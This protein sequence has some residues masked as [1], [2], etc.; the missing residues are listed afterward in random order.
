MPVLIRAECT[1]DLVIFQL[2]RHMVKAQVLCIFEVAMHIQHGG[3]DRPR[4]A[5]A[6][7]DQYH[8]GI[9]RKP[10]RPAGCLPLGFHNVGTDR[11]S[12]IDAFLRMRETGSGCFVAQRDLIDHAG[13]DLIRDPGDHILLLDQRRDMRQ[14]RRH[15]DRPAY[16]AAR[17]DDYIRCEILQDP[18]RLEEAPCRMT[19]DADI[20][21]RQ[22]PLQARSRQRGETIP[23]LRNDT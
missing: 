14:R 17:P 23:F 19:Q 21:Q 7:G 1:R 8:E 2:T 5:A 20:F 12:C 4:S 22:L 11:I 18:A 10:E 3:I 13:K 15:Q 9:R 6:A 16:I